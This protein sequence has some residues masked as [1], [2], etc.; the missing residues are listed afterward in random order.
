MTIP[1]E[2]ADIEKCHLPDTIQFA[3]PTLDYPMSNQTSTDGVHHEDTS[4]HAPRGGELPAAA[5]SDASSSSAISVITSDTP[6]AANLETLARNIDTLKHN[7]EVHKRRNQKLARRVEELEGQKDEA[8]AQ[9]ER[10][11]KER[12]KLKKERDSCM[13]RSDSHDTAQRMIDALRLEL[14]TTKVRVA[15]LHLIHTPDQGYRAHLTSLKRTGTDASGRPT[16]SS[17]ILK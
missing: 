6:S 16:L 13:A 17:S 9:C 11:E 8:D 1:D 5:L 3:S 2:P 10:L 15:I 12:E 7:I 14:R 4:D